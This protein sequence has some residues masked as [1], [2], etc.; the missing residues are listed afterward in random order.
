VRDIN[1]WFDGQQVSAERLVSETAVLG[2]KDLGLDFAIPI[3][4]FQGAEDF[5]TP[6]ELSRRYLA[7][8]KARRK[9]FVSVEGGGHFAGS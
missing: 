8:I 6:A 9:A 1:D 7:S 5:T 2:P 4:V 3:F